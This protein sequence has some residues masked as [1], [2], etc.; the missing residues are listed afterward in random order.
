MDTSGFKYVNDKFCEIFGY[1]K[2]EILNLK[3]Y[4]ILIHPEDR[5]RLNE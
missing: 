3:D 2:D 5:E 1:S 4:P